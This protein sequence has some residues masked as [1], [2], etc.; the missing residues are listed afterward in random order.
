MPI[1]AKIKRVGGGAGTCPP[2]SEDAALWRT[3]TGVYQATKET[4]HSLVHRRAHVDRASGELVGSDE[5]GRPLTPMTAKH[6]E[7]FCRV[8]QR[9]AGAAIACG[10]TPRERSDLDWNLDRLASIHGQS[11]LGGQ[12]MEAPALLIAPARPHGGSALVNAS[13]LLSALRQN[14]SGRRAFDAT[15]ALPD[16]RH[17]L[18]ELEQAPPNE[19]SV[20]LVQLPPW[21]QFWGGPRPS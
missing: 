17:L 3:L 1:K 12:R 16:G 14:F 20:D 6:Q 5:N 19:V 10:L 2:L 21:A 8:V 13:E 7:A 18:V 9:A 4:R 11:P 15:F